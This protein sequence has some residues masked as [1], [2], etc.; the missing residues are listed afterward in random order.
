MVNQR[1]RIFDTTLR[2]GEQS[3]GCSMDLTEKVRLARKLNSA[4]SDLG[5]KL[6]VLV[7]INIGGEAAKSGVSSDST[8]IEDL[9]NAAPEMPF[10]A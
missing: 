3:P 7:E 9:L 10:L 1:V 2:D 8:E 4:A 6:S 5:K